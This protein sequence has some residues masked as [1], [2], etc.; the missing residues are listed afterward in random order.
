[1]SRKFRAVLFFLGAAVAGLSAQEKA[2][3]VDDCIKMAM[4]NNVKVEIAREKINEK[5]AGVKEASASMLPKVSAS[6]NYTRLG[7]A[8][9]ME[10][11]GMQFKAGNE[12]MYSTSLSVTQPLYTGGKITTGRRMA[13]MGLSASEYQRDAAEKDV[14]KDVKKAYYSV[15]AARK[16]L[17]SLDSSIALMEVLVR[18]MG[19]AVDVGMR[20]ENE[21][22]Q[23]E[24]QLLN[25]KLTRQQ[26]ASGAEVATDMLC[27]LIGKP[28]GDSLVL[29]EDLEAPEAF[30]L[31]SLESLQAKATKNYPEVKALEEQLAI[32]EASKKLAEASYL[33][34][35]L[36]SAGLSGKSTG[37]DE[38]KWQNDQSISLLLQWDLY[39]GGA[40]WQ[41]RAQAV[42]QMRQL[43]LT[44]Q[45]LRTNLELMVK[46]NYNSLKVAFEGLEIA[47]KSI[48]QAKKSYD[49][50]YD[51]FQQGLV[52]SSELLNVQNSRLMSEINYYRALSDYFSKR[53]ELDYLITL[54]N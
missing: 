34:N 22:L 25:Q 53:A 1:M 36:A 10:F 17:V 48:E 49:I 52:I 4:E 45:D 26:A 6:A 33:P 35:V 11:N 18:D 3:T 23:A 40:A 13:S 44:L 54:E 15:L 38:L 41:K 31:P 42:S 27:A 51:K 37:V 29:V 46:N 32:V 20:G 30:T 14:T 21:K 2:L 8:P 43:S 47:R 50:T 24:V 39:D 16:S 28:I 7:E 12:N 9:T 19:N 5:T